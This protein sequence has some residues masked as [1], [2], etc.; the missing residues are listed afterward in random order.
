MLQQTQV[1]TVIEYY[2]KWMVKWAT[3]Q[4]LANA[5]IEEVNQM[6][7]GLGYY[8]RARMLHAGA[9]KVV[10]ELN[11]IIPRTSKGLLEL[12]GIGRYTAGA[13]ASIWFKEV[14]PIVDGNV[15]R[16]LSRA[17][18]IGIDP[19]SKLAINTYWKLASELVLGGT[20]PDALNQA[21]MELGATV[22]TSKGPVGCH[23]CPISQDCLA[24]KEA[25]F[26]QPVFREDC[27]LCGEASDGDQPASSEKMFSVTR[28]PR[29]MRLK[30]PKTKTTWI[31]VICNFAGAYLCVQRPQT[32]LLAGLWEFPQVDLD[33]TATEDLE[34][35]AGR[36][37]PI[38]SLMM[39]GRALL[40]RYLTD[41]LKIE[42][43]GQ[44][45]SLSKRGYLGTTLHLF[46]H[47]K[48]VRSAK[49][50][51]FD[52]LGTS[53]TKRKETLTS[54]FHIRSCNNQTLHVEYIELPEGFPTILA[55]GTHQKMQWIPEAEMKGSAF[56]KGMRKCHE[57]YLKYKSDVGKDSINMMQPTIKEMFQ[58]ISQAS[59]PSP[60]P[61]RQRK[62]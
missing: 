18:L 11:G 28:Y 5:T 51:T 21:L 30:A 50:N 16:V 47:I 39:E 20:R 15:I 48:Q 19:K 36:S 22:C 6:W 46:T 55:I 25:T 42:M 26:R 32:G 3:V 62:S 13:I 40:E 23:L 14:T 54:L 37:D 17:R 2:Q 58:Q 8:R 31:A 34:K 44:M 59:S 12:P 61:K 9:V 1:K 10:N 35:V 29:A 60:H 49:E 27:E 24:F 45:Q 4:C 53:P 41:V 33:A 57:M 7:S 43:I 56:S 38:D 52:S